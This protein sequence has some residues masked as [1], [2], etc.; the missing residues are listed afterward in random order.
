MSLMGRLARKQ[1]KSAPSGTHRDAWVKDASVNTV[2]CPSCG[3]TIAIPE[4]PLEIEKAV[5]DLTLGCQN[6]NSTVK[7]PKEAIRFTENPRSTGN[8]V[9]IVGSNIEL[10]EEWSRD[11]G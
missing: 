7:L 4:L 3:F 11:R 6:C 5:T 10:I 9:V 1:Y 2:Q 8:P